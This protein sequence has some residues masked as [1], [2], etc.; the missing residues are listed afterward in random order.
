MERL[1]MFGL[2]VAVPLFFLSAC[3]G[4]KAVRLYDPNTVQPEEVVRV[5]IP[6][7]IAVQTVDGKKNGG[8]SNILAIKEKEL[9]LAPGEY[10]IVVRYSDLWD[11][12]DSHFE[13]FRSR[14]IVLNFKAEAGQTYQMTHPKISS[15]REAK[16]FELNPDIWIE[17]KETRAKAST[18][19]T[20][21][22]ESEK[23]VEDSDTAESDSVTDAGAPPN[24]TEA[25]S[26][27]ENWD[28]MSAEEKEKFQEWL[29]ERN[30]K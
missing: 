15:I 1:L 29:E 23:I 18:L 7:D 22:D 14:E 3:G 24:E 17:E 2:F 19:Q 6:L 21:E 8:F 13:K 25:S 9:Q 16:K 12:D 10:E 26:P 20:G 5:H 30:G 4:T 28:D 11:Y 27:G